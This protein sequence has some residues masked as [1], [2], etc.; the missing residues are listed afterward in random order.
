MHAI[1][2]NKTMK[3]IFLANNINLL[4]EIQIMKKLTCNGLKCFFFILFLF[5]PIWSFAQTQISISEKIEQ[6]SKSNASIKIK[7]P[8]ELSNMTISTYT[9]KYT[10]GYKPQIFE[11]DKSILSTLN[12]G[13]QLYEMEIP[14][15][16][17]ETAIIE[18]FKVNIFDKNYKVY[19]SENRELIVNKG[20]FFHGIVKG[21]NTS[22]VVLSVFENEIDILISD[23]DSDKIIS[24]E[25]KGNLY[26]LEDSKFIENNTYPCGTLSKPD[27][28]IN[29]SIQQAVGCKS[30]L[31][32]IVADNPFYINYGSEQAATNRIHTVFNQAAAKYI[33]HEV[34]IVISEIRIFSV[35]DPFDRTNNQTLLNSFT[36][37]SGSNYYGHAISLFTTYNYGSIIGTAQAYD[38]C[39]KNLTHNWSKVN[40]SYGYLVFAHELGHNFGSGH[41][42][43]GSIMDPTIGPEEFDT[44]TANLLR[45]G[46]ISCGMVD[47]SSPI[48]LTTSNISSTSAIASWQ[49]P[50]TSTRMFFIY[51]RVGDISWIT[52]PVGY[53]NTYTVT[54]L[55]SNTQ[56]VWTVAG[57]CSAGGAFP[58]Y[59]TTP[60]SSN[61]LSF[62]QLSSNNTPTD[63]I[64]AGTIVKEAN[65]TTG[66]ITAT[67]KITNTAKVTYRAG[68]SITLN[69]G[70]KADNG[71]VFKTEFGGCN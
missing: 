41:T 70:F 11:F 10:N 8:F 59:F 57:D 19:D 44:S 13:N 40:N 16:D 5:F 28:D 52:I 49:I 71:V 21:D 68:K 46:A 35:A 66:T 27:I 54:G 67:N 24:K 9:E 2:F 47:N 20:T 22:L 48:Y 50:P 26:I 65:A 51:Q 30:I 43:S 29:K 55:N 38:I 37:W 33:N 42:N 4:S 69:A 60:P 45:N 14:L 39:N 6:I 31:V 3:K 15:G 64:S 1:N 23:K 17:K 36:N 32:S 58:I 18:I 62:L 34:S 12:Q 63:D 53:T 7:N 56:Y 61:C 25:L